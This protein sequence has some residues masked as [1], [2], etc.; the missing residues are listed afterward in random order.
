MLAHVA[1]IHQIENPLLATADNARGSARQEHRPCRSEIEIEIVQKFDVAGCEVILDHDVR[2]FELELDEAVAEV[3][4]TVVGVEGAVRR[5]QVHVAVVVRGGRLSRLPDATVA[6]SRCRGPRSELRQRLRIEGPQHTSIPVTAERDVE[7]PPRQQQPGPL[8]VGAWVEGTLA[9]ARIRWI[10]RRHADDDRRL[11]MRAVLKIESVQ[12]VSQPLRSVVVPGHHI[13]CRLLSVDDWSAENAPLWIVG[14]PHVDVFAT[15]T[16]RSEPGRPEWH[17]APF[18]TARFLVGIVD[19]HGVVHSRDHDSI[20]RAL[21]ERR[22]RVPT[23]VDAQRR[24]VQRLRH[25]LPIGIERPQSAE[26][27]GAHAAGV[28]NVSQ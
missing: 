28:E 17:G 11:S 16:R 4:A 23:S 19:V 8:L 21:H 3:L 10:R 24:D 1:R 9:S 20:E 5:N 26:A 7:N 27:T 13:H 2:S 14:A 18:G 25:D 12:F 22:V 6:S 15:R